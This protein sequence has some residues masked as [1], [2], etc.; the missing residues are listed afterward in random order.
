MMASIS[1][2]MFVSGSAHQYVAIAF[3]FGIGYGVSYPILAAMA[4]HDADPALLAPTLQLFALTYFV[5]I[6]G[7]PLV[8][9]WIIVEVGS[10]SL[11]FIIAI[12]AGIEASLALSRGL[13]DWRLHRNKRRA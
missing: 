11:L 3:L 6:F 12:L 7:F 9:G 8:A 5:G 13:V 2:F 4:A 1:L 10:T